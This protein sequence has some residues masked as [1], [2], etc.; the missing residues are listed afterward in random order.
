MV[1]LTYQDAAIITKSIFDQAGAAII[2]DWS[3]L[4]KNCFKFNLMIFGC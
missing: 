2:Q 1:L 3:E 4:E